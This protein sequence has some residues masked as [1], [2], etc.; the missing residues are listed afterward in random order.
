VSR[1]EERAL[2]VQLARALDGAEQPR[3][4]VAALVTVLERATEPARFELAEDA[5][6]R[7]LARVK[8]RLARP[9]DRRPTSRLALAFGAVATAAVAVLVF[10]F[11][12]LPGTDV[13][14]KAL[15][16]L[17]GVLEIHERVEPVR[18][19]A[20]PTSTRTVWLDPA[21]GLERTVDMSGARVLEETLVTPGRIIRFLPG[22]NL[23]IVG[24]SCRA[25]ASGC[26]DTVDPVAFYRHALAEKGIES[27]KRTDA[28]YEL[29][30]PI[31]TLPDAVRIEQ[32][33]TIDAR[34]YLPTR[35]EWLEQRPGGTLHAVSRIVIASVDRVD[36]NAISDPFQLSLLD[37]TRIEERTV[38]KAPLRKL[39]E[40]SLTLDEARRIK[41]ALLGLPGEPASIDEFRWNA[42]IAYRLRY[43]A[44]TVWNYTNVVPPVLLS[45]V[46]RGP[47][48]VV[49]LG[50]NVVR[51]YP[52]SGGRAFAEVDTRTWSVAI[53][54]PE[55]GKIDVYR[56]AQSLIRLR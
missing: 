23:A 51:F 46:A 39:A 1:R 36:L 17:N 31:R 44:A 41:P 52:A 43:P 7:E 5:V 9:V 16:A 6:E 3:A 50:R 28:G 33:V 47:L 10:T 42:G 37:S 29:T 48:K 12:R 24:S 27:T 56:A 38:S 14:A 15:A 32:V 53:D 34:T 11:V 21:R 18:P 8:P 30:L 2:A 54:A 40:R 25:F 13:E 22:E 35:I 26:A 4:E 45:T 20:F 55:Q 19:G 49:P